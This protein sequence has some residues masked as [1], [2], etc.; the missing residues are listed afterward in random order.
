MAKY[1][2]V[3]GRTRFIVLEPRIRAYWSHS[4][5]WH[6]DTVTLFVEA[7]T[8]PDGITVRLEI[9]EDGADPMD[10]DGCIEAI[11]GLSLKGGRADSSCTLAWDEESL[12]RPLALHN[13]R[14]EFVFDA[15]I[16]ELGLRGRSDAMYVHIHAPLVSA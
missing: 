8:L 12:G 11:E 10:A 13:P 4:R 7:P 15:F 14:R 1:S 16:D 5:A 6:G 2:E 9:R 3:S